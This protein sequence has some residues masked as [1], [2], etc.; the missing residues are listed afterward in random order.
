MIEP[1]RKGHLLALLATLDPI[2]TSVPDVN[3]ADLRD[4]CAQAAHKMSLGN[5]RFL[6]SVSGPECAQSGAED[7]RERRE[8]ADT[9][10]HSS[11]QRS[12]ALSCTSH[13]RV[14]RHRTVSSEALIGEFAPPAQFSRRI[15][16]RGEGGR[17]K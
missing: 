8:R 15:K 10:G 12:P 6:P 3:L 5:A 7:R 4:H 1:V 16:T 11:H 17:H 14:P 2:E 13:S 9:R